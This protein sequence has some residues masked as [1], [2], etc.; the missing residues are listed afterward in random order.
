MRGNDTGWRERRLYRAF[1]PQM[2]IWAPSPKDQGKLLKGF[3][4]G[5][6]T[7]PDL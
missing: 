1:R 7:R 6:V 2:R 5:R 4:L 3:E